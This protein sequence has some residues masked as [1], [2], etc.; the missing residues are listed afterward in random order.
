MRLDTIIEQEQSRTLQRI[1]SRLGGQTTGGD[2]VDL[3]PKPMDTE[4]ELLELCEQLQDP[5]YKLRMVSLP[6]TIQN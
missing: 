6:Y 3:V 4:K 1:N 2:L 5:E